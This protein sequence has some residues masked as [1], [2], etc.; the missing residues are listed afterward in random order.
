VADD[1]VDNASTKSEAR[2]W[3]SKLT[4]YL[5]L[6][7]E[8]DEARIIFKEPGLQAYITENFPAPCR[9]ALQLLPTH[10][11][12]FGP[13]YELLEGFKTDLNFQAEGLSKSSPPFPIE[14]E[15]ELD[16]YAHRV[17]GTVAELCLALVFYHSTSN[18]SEKQRELLV[19]FGGRMGIA[20]QYVNIA[21][22]IATDS[23]IG[24][25]Y[26]PSTWLKQVTLT[27]QD[28]I[29]HPEGPAIEALREYLLKRAFEIYRKAKGALQKL[30]NEARGPMRV[31]VESYMEIGRV[32]REGEHRV[33]EGKATVPK[34]RRIKV[35]WNSL[36]EG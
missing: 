14:T 2:E 17:A 22:D 35:A 21:R 8:S 20:L 9:S 31:A 6:A 36:S 3:I 4:H 10:L 5:D 30:P 11:L 1:L 13:L 16:V 19:R 32:L 29:K 24:R 15:H 12:P 23:R 27:P 25:V 33:K 26:I 34:L 28:V 18:I 7:Y